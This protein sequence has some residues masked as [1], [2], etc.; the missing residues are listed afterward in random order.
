MTSFTL[1]EQMKEMIA[2][3]KAAQTGTATCDPRAMYPAGHVCAGTTQPIK[4]TPLIYDPSKIIRRIPGKLQPPDAELTKSSPL[5]NG[6]VIATIET[7]TDTVTAVTDANGAV[8]K[9]AV[10]QKWL[11]PAA[12]AAAAFLLFGG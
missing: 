3:A 5:P 11:V 6:G 7:P 8:K 12:L 1:T 4:S 10:Q 9:V 2:R